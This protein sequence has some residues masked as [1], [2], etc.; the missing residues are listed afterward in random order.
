[1]RIPEGPG[2]RFDGGVESGQRVSADF[3]PLLAK[4]I[5]HGGDRDEAIARARRGLRDTVLLGVTHNASYLERVLAHPA[6]ADGQTHTGFLKQHAEK[7]REQP[8]SG[9]ERALLLAAAALT[10]RDF[11]ERA[12]AVPEPYR[13]MGGWRN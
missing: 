7:I 5:A 6:F 10:D 3:D 4:L 12:A 8:P 13:S 9:D 1:V 2:L 11:L